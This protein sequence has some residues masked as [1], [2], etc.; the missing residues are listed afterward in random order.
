MNIKQQTLEAYNNGASQLATKFNNMGARIDDI[1]MALSYMNKANPKIL[2][3]GCGNGRDAKEIL[4]YTN[5]YTGVDFS[6]KLIKLA[7]NYAPGGKYQVTDFEDYHFP[8]N[9]DL[10]FAFASLLHS[11]RSNI[12]KI[13]QQ[14][15]RALNKNGVFLI[16]LKFD[17]YHKAVKKED[18][19]T[20]TFYFYTPDDICK[21]SPPELKPIY[22]DIQ[23]LR[24]QRWFTIILQKQ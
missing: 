8:N 12:K 3:L 7:G 11:N 20:R 23:D 6:E 5:D 10:I 9:L 4:K 14:A 24:D 22:Q 17:N 1:K 13:L 19:G 21:L 15:F 18:I 2:E 16:S